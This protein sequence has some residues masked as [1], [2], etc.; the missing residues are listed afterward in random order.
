MI[1]EDHSVLV[2]EDEYLVA[3]EIVDL[4]EQWGATIMGTVQSPAQ[5]LDLLAR[6]TPD[7]AV[8]DINLRGGS[9]YS[10]ADALEAAGV[11]F[12]LVTGYDNGCYPPVMPASRVARSRSTR[13]CSPRCWRRR[14]RTR[15]KARPSTA[16][17]MA[18]SVW[19][20]RPSARPAR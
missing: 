3:H 4:L 6:E 9:A 8:L 15:G 2:V 19:A 17:G 16:D 20:R 14:C 12:I 18:A 10:V 13:R 11:P 7:G 1:F 5:A